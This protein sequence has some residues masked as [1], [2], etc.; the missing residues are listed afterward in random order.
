MDSIED[1]LDAITE[2]YE[3]QYLQS[4]QYEPTYK[5]ESENSE[6]ELFTQI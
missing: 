2:N 4:E 3:R 6:W 5:S 1:K